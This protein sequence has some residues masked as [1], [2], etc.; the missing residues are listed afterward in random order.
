MKRANFNLYLYFAFCELR[1]CGRDRFFHLRRNT[2]QFDAT[3]STY[4]SLLCVSSAYGCRVARVRCETWLWIMIW[5]TRQTWQT[6]EVVRPLTSNVALV[7]ILSYS[8]FTIPPFFG[9]KLAS[10]CK[11][12]YWTSLLRIK[13]NRPVTEEQNRKTTAE[14]CGVI[15]H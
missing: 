2:S 15:E 4:F 6:F 8:P 12:P 14:R 11:P 9:A 10:I 13:P 7:A 5:I 3:T 1:L